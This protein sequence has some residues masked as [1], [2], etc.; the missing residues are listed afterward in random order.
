MLYNLTEDVSHC[1][2]EWLHSPVSFH[3][4]PRGALLLSHTGRNSHPTGYATLLK[5]LGTPTSR[6]GK[7]TRGR[8]Q[9]EGRVRG[10]CR[11]GSV[12]PRYGETEQAVKKRKKKTA[13]KSQKEVVAGAAESC[14]TWNPTTLEKDA[15]ERRRRRVG[16]E[17]MWDLRAL[18]YQ[19]LFLVF[20]S[21][22]LKK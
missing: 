1:K 8:R 16:G 10:R 18:N 9:T 20:F 15:A 11:G 12:N 3:P 4:S 2:K 14:N 7:A 22:S 5:Y 21:S 19:Q 13:I 17:V 6:V